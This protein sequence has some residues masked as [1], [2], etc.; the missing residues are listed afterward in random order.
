MNIVEKGNALRIPKIYRNLS[1]LFSF[2]RYFNFSKDVLK[3]C[4]KVEISHFLGVVDKM[5]YEIR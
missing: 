2:L 3:C 5:G 4:L 1:L